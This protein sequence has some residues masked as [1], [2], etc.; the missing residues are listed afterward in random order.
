MIPHVGQPVCRGLRLVMEEDG[1]LVF[2]LG[3]FRVYEMTLQ[4]DTLA[5]ISPRRGAVWPGTVN[6]LVVPTRILGVPLIYPS[7]C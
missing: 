2:E 7:G 3:H 1:I 6:R 4:H 5:L